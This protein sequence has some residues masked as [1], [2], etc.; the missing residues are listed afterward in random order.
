MKQSAD[1]YTKKTVFS[2]KGYLNYTKIDLKTSTDTPFSTRATVFVP[3]ANISKPMPKECLSLSVGGDTIRLVADNSEDLLEYIAELYR[4]VE[5][6][7]DM[8]DLAC[9]IEADSWMKKQTAYHDAKT[10]KKT[11][12]IPLKQA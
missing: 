12:I 11:A 1:I 10:P 2:E 5:R 3:K 9:G 4:F 6:N 8:L 7:Q